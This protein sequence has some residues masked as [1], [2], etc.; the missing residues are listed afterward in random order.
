MINIGLDFGSTYTVTSV[1]SNGQPKAV[2]LSQTAATP[3]IPT[4]VSKNKK[5]QYEYGIIA[6]KR[7]ERSNI[8][9]FKAFK[10]LLSETN[11]EILKERG[12]EGEDQP[13]EISRRYLEKTLGECLKACGEEEIGNLVVGVP[14]IWYEQLAGIDCCTKIRDI[15]KSLPFVHEVQVVS[16]PAAA[17]AYFVWNYKL[18]RKEDF[19][20]YILLIDYGGGTLDITLNEV[21]CEDG[22]TSIQV[23]DR[24]GAGENE[25]GRIGKA[26]IVFMESVTAEA[27]QKQMGEEPKT[28]EKF[29]KAV[30]SFEEELQS[31]SAEVEEFYEQ[32]TLLPLETLEEEFTLLEY[33]GEEVEVSY[34]LMY[35]V[36]Q[37]VIAGVLDEKLGEIISYM[38]KHGID[39]R[40]SQQ[41]GFKIAM[42]G[43]FSNFYLVRR[44]IKQ[45]FGFTSQDRRLDG[46]IKER[47][48]CENAIAFG[49]ALI[50]EQKI[51]IPERAPYA[52]GIYTENSD[53]A[54]SYAVKYREKIECGKV[55]YLKNPKDQKERIFMGSRIRQFVVNPSEDDRRGIVIAPSR[56]Y[57]EKLE[58]GDLFSKN[59]IQTFAIGFSWD[60]SMVL[61]LHIKEFQYLTG[62]FTGREKSIELSRLSD[63]FDLVELENTAHG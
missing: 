52:I 8:Q 53:Q 49:A 59:G 12:F 46:I 41:E 31:R 58:I 43:G 29:Y 60:H 23:K 26:G 3:F 34:G 6:R 11:P 42:A 50:A 20:G 35:Q 63:L 21:T 39:Y 18:S 13:E 51:T 57:Q 24:T 37:K 61:S 32:N 4:V 1:L 10:M 54:F 5:G 9:I 33:M 16:E 28:D 17:S 22:E 25:E 2:L 45:R 19:K 14:E 36:Y 40:N 30:Y 44:Q 47:T 62:E 7:A 56:K 48:D 27:I 38:E 55:Y 15:C